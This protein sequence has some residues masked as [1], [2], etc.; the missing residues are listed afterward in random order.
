MNK[1]HEAKARKTLLNVFLVNLEHAHQNRRSG[2]E[3]TLPMSQGVAELVFDG[4]RR[5]L[6]GEADPFRLKPP[7]GIKS[8]LSRAQWQFM[9]AVVA[10]LI[11]DG[12]TSEEAFKRAGELFDMS[13]QAAK[14]S[15]YE[16][17]GSVEGV[18]GYH[19][20]DYAARVIAGEDFSKIVP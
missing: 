2:V 15:Y 4:I 8:R 11:K 1:H 12:S 17:R 5:A 10:R 16:E 20:R 13:P 19:W 14:Q 3:V 18:L 7:R 9:A 6:E